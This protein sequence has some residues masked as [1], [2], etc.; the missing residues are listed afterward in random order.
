MGPVTGQA[1]LDSRGML[2]QIRPPDFSV[3]F[4]ALQVHVLRIDQAVCDG[5]MR[6][7]AVRALDFSFPY[8]VMGLP[9]QLGSDLLMAR[10]TDFGLG[11]LCKVFGISLMNAVTI[12]T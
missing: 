1:I 11:G 9:Q 6:V 4:K 5:P 8:R 3:T 10:D 7:V 12:G 2:P